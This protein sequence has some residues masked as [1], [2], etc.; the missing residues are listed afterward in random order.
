MDGMKRTHMCADLSAVNINEKVTIMGWVQ[1]QRN[2][3]GLLFVSMR[4]RSGI[5][6][7]VFNDTTDRDI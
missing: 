5:V 4:D 6:Q 1:R 2:L 3:G 7:V